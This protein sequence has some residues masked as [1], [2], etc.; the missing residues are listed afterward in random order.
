MLRRD[1][2]P[3][4]TSAREQLERFPRQVGL[5]LET[6]RVP[7]KHNS[8]IPTASPIT[9]LPTNWSTYGKINRSVDIISEI[10]E[11]KNLENTFRRRLPFTEGAITTTNTLACPWGV[12]QCYVRQA[13]NTTPR[14]SSMQHHLHHYKSYWLAV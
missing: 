8:S 14:R 4:Y 10:C 6:V 7:D 2:L 1:E 3:S 13:H 11:R 9:R 5:T 12:Q